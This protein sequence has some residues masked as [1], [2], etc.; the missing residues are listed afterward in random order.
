MFHSVREGLARRR[1]AVQ[2]RCG[3]HQDIP[4]PVDEHV[5]KSCVIKLSDTLEGDP[6]VGVLHMLPRAQ[7]QTICYMSSKQDI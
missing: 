5:M 7:D 6:F 2:K 1:R 3:S 4:Y